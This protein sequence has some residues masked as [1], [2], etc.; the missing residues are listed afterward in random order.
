MDLGLVT[1]VTSYW[2]AVSPFAPPLWKEARI[3]VFVW[4]RCNRLYN[5]GHVMQCLPRCKYSRDMVGASVVV[6]PS[7]EVQSTL[8]FPVWE[9]LALCQNK[10]HI[11]SHIVPKVSIHYLIKKLKT[12]FVWMIYINVQYHV[13]AFLR[14]CHQEKIPLNLSTCVPLDVKFIGV[15]LMK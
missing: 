15:I 14:I 5:P 4:S 3:P 2:L 8:S 12:T 7:T 13:L 1:S 9:E 11:N 6:C 10:Y